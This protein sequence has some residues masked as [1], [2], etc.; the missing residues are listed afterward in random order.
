MKR[1][2]ILLSYGATNVGLVRENNEDYFIRDDEQGLYIVADGLGGQPAGEDASRIACETMEGYFKQQPRPFTGEMIDRAIE[3]A[4]RAV[5]REASGSP[6][7]Q[8]MGTT[9]VVALW[10][11]AGTFRVANVGDSR[12]YLLRGQK[13][14]QLTTDDSLVAE[15]L[16]SG[17]ITPWEAGHYYSRNV[18]TQTLGAAA[19]KKTHQVPVAVRDGDLLLLCSD[20]LWDLVPDE[21]MAV[22]LRAEPDLQHKCFGLIDAAKRAGGPDNITAVIVAVH[23]EEE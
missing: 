5:L 6:D 18:L 21:D 23:A 7:L 20:G 17:S 15:L 19:R 11:P 22:I 8:G 9:A 4:N 16:V 1:K 3:E 14:R 13:L 2:F 10:Q 12:G